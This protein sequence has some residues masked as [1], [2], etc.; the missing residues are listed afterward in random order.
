VKITG[1]LDAPRYRVDLGA[2]VEQ[3][4]RQKAEEKLKEQ[5]QDRLKGLLRR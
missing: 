2:T 3:A 5:L 4:A 1:P